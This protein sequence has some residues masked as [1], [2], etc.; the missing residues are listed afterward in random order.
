MKKLFVNPASFLW[1]NKHGINPIRGFSL[2]RLCFK[3]LF[4]P[5]SFVLAFS[6]A[7]L[8]KKFLLTK[9]YFIKALT[10]VENSSSHT[11]KLSCNFL[12][13]HHSPHAASF[14]L[15]FH[16]NVRFLPEN[17]KRVHSLKISKLN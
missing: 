10:S 4:T 13:P 5:T 12:T 17:I 15:H 7:I 16:R 2:T 1:E 6:H 14:S 11:L 8:V 3:Q 9:H